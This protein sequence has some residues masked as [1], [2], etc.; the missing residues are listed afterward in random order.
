MKKKSALQEGFI[1]IILGIVL[2][3]G[4]IKLGLGT[5]HQPGS[6]FLPS[7][8]GGS[9]VLLGLILILYKIYIEQTKKKSEFI[10]ISATKFG[11]K[12]VYS[13][14]A[15]C[16]YALLLETLGFIIA[17]LLLLFFLFKIMNPRKWLNPIL[18]SF[19]TVILSYLIFYSWLRINFP[20][21]IF[22]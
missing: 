3:I 19:I 21:G 8:T 13:F 11:K 4:S 2:F 22:K 15:L 12:R 7:L 18:I 14:V 10:G 16:M 9:L 5:L 6:G 20:K 17:T 1:W